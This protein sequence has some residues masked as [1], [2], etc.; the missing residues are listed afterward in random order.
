[1]TPA[2]PSR[3]CCV[4]K[5]LF[6]CVQC[7]ERHEKRK[8][9]EQQL[10]CPLC[11]THKFP[12]QSLE[13][14]SLFCHIATAH[15][16]LHCTLC[17]DIFKKLNDLES[18]GTCKWW[19]SRHRN[20]LTSDQKSL[21]G[22]SPFID[23]K[24]NGY[25]G[26]FVSLTSPPELQRNTSTPMVVSQKNNLELK[27]PIVP[28]FSLKTPKTNS[29][30]LK[31]Q[32]HSDFRDSGTSY[33]VSFPS[34]V[35]H[36]ETPFRSVSS[37]RGNADN[38]PR[39]NSMQ[40]AVMKEQEEHNSND[41][42]RV[43]DMELTGVEGEVLSDTR[44][45]C[46]QE[47][48]RRRSDSLKKV[49]FSDQYES[50]VESNT[51]N[52]YN[53]TE[54]EEFFE[55]CDTM[56]D[57][58]ESLDKARIQIYEE[59]AKNIQKEN[60]RPNIPSVDDNRSSS[61]TRFVMMMVMEDR[62]N[63]STSDL[64][65]SGLK[66][67]EGITSN[68]NMSK[69]DLNSIG[70]SSSTKTVNSHCSVSSHECYSTSIQM[71]DNIRRDSSSSNSSGGS[72]SSSGLFYTV[73]NAVKS[74]VK[75]ISGMTMSGNMEREQVSQRED[76]VPRPS[77]SNTFVP[78]SQFAA[79]LLQRPGKRPRDTLDSSPSSKRQIGSEISQFEPTSPLH[80]RHRGWY[81]IKGREPIARMRN[82][83]LTSPRGV[84]SETQVFHQG[85]LSVGDTVLPLPSR[86][87]QSTQTD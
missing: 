8:H 27:T 12:L 35:S 25:N 11:T 16:P 56:T 4:C 14:K 64:I 42:H 54:N 53:V 37:S 62:S 41:N 30:S 85:S 78:M 23:G 24:E 28:D 75:S 86:A 63:L 57:T 6:C 59:N 3:A 9:T 10:K 68:I 18:F 73:A 33:Y 20:S 52:N 72:N 70:C 50:A 38:L 45:L 82:S 36:K 83:H 31:S 61:T 69:S 5:K 77:T 58:Q 21:L 32:I 2:E 46:V 43:E 49:R 87:H 71:I 65:N 60:Y 15:L 29:P 79:S 39:S 7:R 84:S 80:K 13:D 19:K 66:K 67:F 51:R 26:N 47:N 40:L 55:A 81:R 76:I 74:V 1:M 48:S 17:G 22:T 44:G 34:A